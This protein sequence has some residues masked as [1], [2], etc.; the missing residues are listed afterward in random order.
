MRVRSTWNQEAIKHRTAGMSKQADPYTMNQDHVEKQ[1]AADEYVIGG[2]SDFAEDIHPSSQWEVEY[3][4]DGKVKRNEIGQPDFRS[5][6]FNHPEKT[7]SMDDAFLIKKAKLAEV[8]ARLM[9]KGRRFANESA[10][11]D[12]IEEMGANLMQLSN[13]ALIDTHNRLADQDEFPGGDFPPVDDIVAEDEGA[14]QS[15]QQEQAEQAIESLQQNDDEGAKQALEQMVQQAIQT[16][17][18]KQ[19]S[20]MAAM[21]QKAVSAA[22]A[23][24]ANEQQQ[25]QQAPAQEQAIDEAPQQVEADDMGLVDEMLMDDE[26]GD[27]EMDEPTVNDLDIELDQSAM[28]YSEVPMGPEDDILTQIFADDQEDPIE[29]LQQAPQAQQQARQARVLTAS[30]TVGTR[31]TGGVSKIGGVPSVGG[32]GVNNLSNLW[33]SAPDV[34]NVFG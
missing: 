3:G 21:V 20:M 4:S 17:Q 30:R 10:A 8:T 18:A 7:A 14:E 12:A 24:F 15:V 23:K 19:A 32:K 5:E 16:Q 22:F 33:A 34:S 6:T 27:F 29:Q 9:L 13:E 25:V 2:P 31:P 11:M 28:D 26:L 1:P